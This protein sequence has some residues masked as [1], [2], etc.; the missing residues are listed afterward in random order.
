MTLAFEDELYDMTETATETLLDDDL[1]YRLEADVIFDEV[2]YAGFR[3]D[4][5]TARFDAW[6]CARRKRTLGHLTPL[7]DERKYRRSYRRLQTLE[8]ISKYRW[9]HDDN[10]YSSEQSSREV[11]NWLAD[12]DYLEPVTEA[13]L[14][15]QTQLPIDTPRDVDLTEANQTA[16]VTV[17]YPDVLTI[18]AFELKQRDWEQALRQAI[19]S[20]CYADLRWVV[21]DGGAVDEAIQNKKLFHDSGVGLLSLDR[22]DL[23]IHVWADKV[24]PAKSTTRQLINERA[25][26][27]CPDSVRNEID[28][29]HAELE[30]SG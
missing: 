25:L 13:G 15:Q 29:K 3:T 4:L 11:W 12:H 19:R 9:V 5:V 18:H 21:M 1:P 8:P 24:Y 6:E 16:A 23:E 7:P 10:T 26:A 14:G 2:P 20:D 22:D 17:R 28:E 27:K 30:D